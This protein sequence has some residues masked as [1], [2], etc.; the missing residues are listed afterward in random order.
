MFAGESWVSQAVSHAVKV[1]TSR[2]PEADRNRV[3]D[4]IEDLRGL[5]DRGARFTREER[6]LLH[7]SCT[8]EDEDGFNYHVLSLIQRSKT[9]PEVRE[10]LAAERLAREAECD[11]F[12][13]EL[14][15]YI[16]A[17]R[18]A[19]DKDWLRQN[20]EPGRIRAPGYERRLARHRSKGQKEVARR[21]DRRL[22]QQERECLAV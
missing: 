9:S 3:W 10:R 22:R 21:R 8:P 6:Q 7:A 12:D 17:T 20:C 19:S 4:A 2:G 15:R 13:R 1:V 16:C 5:M 18:P 14:E 11:A